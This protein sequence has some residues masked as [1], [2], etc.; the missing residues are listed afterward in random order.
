MSDLVPPFVWIDG[1]LT[2]RTTGLAVVDQNG[3]PIVWAEA[4]F[5]T[6]PPDTLPT[7][8]VTVAAGAAAGRVTFQARDA[9]ESL[10]VLTD[11]HDLGSQRSIIV[12]LSGQPDPLTVTVEEPE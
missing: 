8:I 9:Q 4:E 11:D 2:S 5:T 7:F 12:W 6:L 1:V 3:D 10:T